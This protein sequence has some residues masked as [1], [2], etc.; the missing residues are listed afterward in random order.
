MTTPDPTP[1]EIPAEMPCT[2]GTCAC[3][4]AARAARETP[5]ERLRMALEVLGDQDGRVDLPAL[6]DE[7]RDL[8]IEVSNL[9]SENQRLREVKQRARAVDVDQELAPGVYQLVRYIL[10]EAS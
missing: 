8:R 2:C 5:A 4:A 9:R 7:L 6:A 3:I 1:A 10:G